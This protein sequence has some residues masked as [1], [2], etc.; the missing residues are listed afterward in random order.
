MKYLGGKFRTAGEISAYINSVLSEGQPYWEPFVGAAW[1]LRRIVADRRY[2]SDI[3]PYLIGMWKALL[4]GWIPPEIVTEQEYA[5]I[6][7]NKDKYPPELVAF[8]GFAASWG[9][10]WFGGYARDPSS[11]RNYAKEGVAS[12]A[13]SIPNVNNAI[14]FTADFFKRNPPE[15]NMLIYCDPPYIGTTRYDYSPLFNHGDFWD[16]VRVLEEQGHNVIV[17]EY[18]APDDFKC[19]LKI[20]TKTDLS[21]AGGAKDQRVERLFSLTPLEER[22]RQLTFAF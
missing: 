2:A 13:R 4:Q 9:G 3:N 15:S 22:F 5:D 8:I 17:S 20:N 12:L 11:D 14:F 10:K 21:M 7:K 1:I 6:K 18:T 19:V 16:R